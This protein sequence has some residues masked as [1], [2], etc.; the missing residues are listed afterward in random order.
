MLKTTDNSFDPYD[1]HVSKFW[2]FSFV[3]I[4]KI[5]SYCAIDAKDNNN[6]EENSDSADEESFMER[7]KF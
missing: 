5:L 6:S 1:Y 3:K 4:E 7:M 2:K